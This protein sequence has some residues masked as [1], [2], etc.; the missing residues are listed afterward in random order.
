MTSD[1]G[2]P[3]DTLTVREAMN[4]VGLQIFPN[5]WNGKEYQD[6][7]KLGLNPWPSTKLRGMEAV[8]ELLRLVWSEIVTVEREI[9][10]EIY[11]A[12]APDEVFHFHGPS[13]SVAGD[14][15]AYR[16]CRL[17]FPK[18]EIKVVTSSGGRKGYDYA[19]LVIRIL[20]Y[21][22]AQGTG[23][24]IDF[25]TRTIRL[26]LEKDEKW[27]GKI[28]SYSRLQPYV[29]AL[30]AYRCTTEQNFPKSNSGTEPCD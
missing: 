3:F 7:W 25:I 5:Q 9:E 1:K 2:S 15:E 17:R 18:A 19:P 22:D 21:L 28:P 26:D 23:G 16:P 14:E 12:I 13:S 27:V 20:E 10:D 29:S 4:R 30:R 8:R 11:Q 24:S 6:H